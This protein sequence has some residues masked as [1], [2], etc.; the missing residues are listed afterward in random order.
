MA[1]EFKKLSDVEVLETTTE[2]TNILVEENGEIVKTSPNNFKTG[3][4]KTPYDD[5][6]NE[7]GT[8]PSAIVKNFYIIDGSAYGVPL[9]NYNQY[10]AA[11]LIGYYR[12][13]YILKNF[14]RS[15][16]LPTGNTSRF[17]TK[18]KLIKNSDN[19]TFS[20]VFYFGDDIAPIIANEADNS[21]TLDPD[22]VAPAEPIPV[23]TTA[24]VGQVV[25]VKAVDENGKPTEWEAVDGGGSCGGIKTAII[26]QDGYDNALAGIATAATGGEEVNYTC[27]N[28]TFEEAKQILLSGESLVAIFKTCNDSGIWCKLSTNTGIN[29]YTGFIILWD[30]IADVDVYWWEN[31]I[32]TGYPSE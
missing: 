12:K 18:Y 16:M 8:I 3:L 21:F 19:T 31:G 22:W 17:C 10:T 4:L 1:F 26:K 2:A 20:C 24:E 9:N 7:D 11:E 15:I 13:G 5:Y 14:E 27:E 23:P 6:A 32:S 29:R 30:P 28:M 25:A